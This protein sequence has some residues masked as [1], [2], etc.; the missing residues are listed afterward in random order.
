MEAKDETIYLNAICPF[1]FLSMLRG[2]VL[3]LQFILLKMGTY[4]SLQP[5]SMCSRSSIHMTS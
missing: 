4:L 5:I 1:S 2:F 3:T